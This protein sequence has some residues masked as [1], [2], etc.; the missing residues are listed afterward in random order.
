MINQDRCC[1]GRFKQERRHL[2]KVSMQ[3]I[4]THHLQEDSLAT[5]FP[6]YYIFFTTYCSKGCYKA[7][8]L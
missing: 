6:T 2:I 7:F 5:F 3:V 8:F 1:E 4:Q